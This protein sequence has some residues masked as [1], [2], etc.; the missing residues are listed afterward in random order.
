M[1][2]TILALLLSVWATLSSAAPTTAEQLLSNCTIEPETGRSVE[3]IA[4]LFVWVG[5]VSG[6][7]D[8]HAVM[9]G[10]YQSQRAFCPPEPGIFP[11]VALRALAQWLNRDPDDGAT[12]ARLALVLALGERYPC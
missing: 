5:Y 11:D 1:I 4:A 9:V 3:E 7:L 8:R 12:S 10:L 6:L 2:R